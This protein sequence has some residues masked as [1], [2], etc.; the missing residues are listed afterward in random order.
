[1]TWRPQV[2]LYT[3]LSG[4]VL[5]GLR[6]Q[7]F[8]VIVI[9]RASTVDVGGGGSSRADRHRAKS[10]RW[11]GP[12][13]VLR[14][15]MPPGDP[16]RDR[17]PPEL[18]IEFPTGIDPAASGHVPPQRRAGT[19][20]GTG[21]ASTENSGNA[22]TG[23][24]MVGPVIEA[25]LLTDAESAEVERRMRAAE[26]RRLG[27]LAGRW[28]CQH[29]SSTGYANSGASKNESERW[30]APAGRSWVWCSRPRSGL[31]WTRRTSDATSGTR[32]RTPTAWTR[33][34]DAS[35]ATPQ[36]RLAAV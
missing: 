10:G 35:R 16:D 12:R 7:I 33:R 8:A 36:L 22:H 4:P 11:E 31:P 18:S 17:I 25:E 9:D 24:A 1:V 29:G 20:P 26:T 2:S 21:S 5:V 15:R 30:R 6:Q 23:G 14:L 13:R 28:P 34:L 19:G 3:A 32:S 27:N